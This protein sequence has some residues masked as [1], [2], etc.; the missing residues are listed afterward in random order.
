MLTIHDISV[1]ARRWLWL[2]VLVPLAAA[3]L[4]YKVSSGLPKVYE[5]TE[6]L[7]IVPG[8]TSGGSASYDAVLSA[9]RLTHTYSEIVKSRRVVGA[10]AAAA[11]LDLSYDSALALVSV[12]PLRDTQ[13]LQVSARAGDPQVAARFANELAAAFM[14]QVETTRASRFA[15]SKDSLSKQ[16]DQLSADVTQRTRQADELRA[17]PASGARDTELARVQ[18]ELAQLQ[19]AYQ[20]AERSYEA[21]RVSEARTNALVQVLDA[22]TPPDVPVQPRLAQNVLLAA[23]AGLLAALGLAFGVEHF[24]DRLLSPDRLARFTGL[25]ALGS[26]GI[27][28]NGS[29]DPFV[30]E[31]FRLLRANLEFLAVERPLQALLV[32]SC[33]PG[34]GKSSTSRYLAQV[35]AQAGQTVILIDADLRRPSQHTLFQLPNKGGLTSLLTNE[36]VPAENMLVPTSIPGLKLL[37]SGPLPPNPSELLASHRMRERL[38]ELRRLADLLIVDSSPVLP[39]SDPAV[40][41]SW[42]DG[43]LLVVNVRRTRGQQ[44]AHAVATLTTAGARVL[45]AVLNRAARGPHTYYSYYSA[46]LESNPVATS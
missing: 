33:D 5:S 21:I 27:Y 18:F 41:A 24:D 16:V 44:A 23:L 20:D 37:P 3:A 10:A 8:E 12:V 7:L 1:L 6:R 34:D 40:L 43:T 26:I 9:E 39:V 15:V 13:I 42:V 29:E 11:G 35:A 22:A 38:T 32:T 17:Q 46:A 31:A 4:S 30:G 19:P 28:K 36:A 14:Q 45:G 2:L 25:H